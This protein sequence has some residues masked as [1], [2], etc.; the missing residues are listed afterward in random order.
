MGS[1]RNKLLVLRPSI[2]ALSYFLPWMIMPFLM[3]GGVY[4]CYEGTENR[5]SVFV[6]WWTPEIPL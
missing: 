6:H 5:A 3:L 1:L 2:L 4:L